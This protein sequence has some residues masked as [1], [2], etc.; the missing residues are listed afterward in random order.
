MKSK[1][2]KLIVDIITEKNIET[3]EELTQQLRDNGISVTQ[4]TISRDIKELGLVKTPISKNR[5]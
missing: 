3:Q 2:H 5:Y 1:R 4:A